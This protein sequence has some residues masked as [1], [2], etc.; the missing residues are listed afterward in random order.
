MWGSASERTRAMSWGEMLITD[1][2]Y[3]SGERAADVNAVA[4]FSEPT[5][6]AKE[7]SSAIRVASPRGRPI[8]SGGH[9]TDVGRGGAQH[10][11]R[12]LLLERVGDPR[13]RAGYGENRGERRAR[14][15]DG[16][17]QQGR[18]HFDI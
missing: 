10:S 9:R 4:P 3:R 2:P 15:A 13:R 7:G 8:S 5:A 1:V 11:A 12:A 17:E 14:H 18:I 16:V 6:A